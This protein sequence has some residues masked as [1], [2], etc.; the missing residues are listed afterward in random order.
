[1]DHDG[2]LREKTESFLKKYP[3]ATFEEV[4]HDETASAEQMQSELRAVQGRLHEAESL[5]A[6]D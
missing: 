3:Q 6:T 4:E 2:S 1:M 5:A